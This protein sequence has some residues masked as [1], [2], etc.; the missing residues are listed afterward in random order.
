[1]QSTQHDNINH[2]IPLNNN[3]YCHD[4]ETFTSSFHFPN[5]PSNTTPRELFTILLLASQFNTTLFRPC[6]QLKH[7]VSNIVSCSLLYLNNSENSEKDW[8]ITF[9]YVK[10]R[11]KL[12]VMVLQREPI[13]ISVGQE[14]CWHCYLKQRQVPPQVQSTISSVA[15]QR[16]SSIASLFQLILGLSNY[17]PCRGCEITH[18]PSHWF[19]RE[20]NQLLLASQDGRSQ[21]LGAVHPSPLDG[22]P[23][24][25]A[26]E[27]QVL[28]A[29]KLGVVR[30]AACRKLKVT[31]YRRLQRQEKENIDPSQQLDAK[32]FHHQ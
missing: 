29:N 10:L 17:V 21:T 6:T 26:S 30:C 9:H 18:Y 20:N 22:H 31:L 14:L 16:L 4:K 32:T 2:P 28:L 27:C 13:T 8:L 11:K 1:M 25:Y 12:T 24:L 23:V 19:Y 5:F 7:L 3:N 15:S